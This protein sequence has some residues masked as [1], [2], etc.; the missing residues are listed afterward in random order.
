MGDRA[1]NQ[2]KKQKN[3]GEEIMEKKNER[4]EMQKKVR[5]TMMD[6]HETDRGMF[7]FNHICGFFDHKH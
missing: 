4:E 5:K 3:I 1:Q 6:F 7:Y 2:P